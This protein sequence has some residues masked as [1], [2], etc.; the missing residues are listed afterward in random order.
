MSHETHCSKA[1]H[2]VYIGVINDFLIKGATALMLK[3]G[4]LTR[5]FL[6]SGP[7]FMTLRSH[8]N[9]IKLSQHAH[10]TVIS[11]CPTTHILSIFYFLRNL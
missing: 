5:P 8:Q 4:V 2:R 1:T 11:L 10:S 9:I 3:V 7:S 6:T